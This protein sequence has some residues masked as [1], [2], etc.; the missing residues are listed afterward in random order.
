MRILRKFY[1]YSEKHI[2]YKILN[3]PLTT[4]KRV[5]GIHYRMHRFL[6]ESYHIRLYKALRIIT[7]AFYFFIQK[8]VT[9]E[10]RDSTESHVVMA[11]DHEVSK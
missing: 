3:E 7:Q 1:I 8:F 11:T 9:R 10:E 2:Q 5:Y 6:K 4:L